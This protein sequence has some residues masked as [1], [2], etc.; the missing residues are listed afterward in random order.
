MLSFTPVIVGFALVLTRTG[1][2]VLASPVLGQGTGFSGYR[3][4]LI[5]FLSLLLYV[6]VGTPVQ[7][8]TAFE[9]VLMGMREA[10]LGIFLGFLMQLSLL[11][12]RV[13]GELVGQEMGFLIARQVDPSSGVP[14][15]L[16]TSL[17]ENLFLLVLLALDGHHWLLRSLERS[18]AQAPVGH[19]TIGERLVPTAL[20][21]FGEMFRAGIVFAAPVLVFLLIISMVIGILS[22]AVPGINV[23][24]VGFGLRVLVALIA[25]FLFAP[26]MEPAMRALNQDLLR[27]FERGVAAL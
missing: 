18:F 12:L 23:M 24:D 25:L 5:L 7:G 19:L 13:A 27:W 1:A 8:A 26:L 20:S 16:I 17:Y 6:A 22:R 21:M 11:T 15:T 3:V 14:S 10:L 4:A 2:L 9:I